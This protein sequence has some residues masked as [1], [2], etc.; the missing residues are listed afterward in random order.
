M[1]IDSFPNKHDVLNQAITGTLLL[2]NRRLGSDAEVAR[3]IG[4]TRSAITKFKN[5]D[6]LPSLRVAWRLSRLA[7]SEGID[8]VADAF[9]E[10]GKRT[11]PAPEALAPPNC[12]T[13]EENEALLVCGGVA[14]V[15]TEAFAK[16]RHRSLAGTWTIF[17]EPQPVPEVPETPTS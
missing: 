17:V 12:S 1:M 2:L 8:L 3:R 16:H 14:L 7:S 5:G 13:Q 10:E 4:V 9:S 11:L 6:A 15:A